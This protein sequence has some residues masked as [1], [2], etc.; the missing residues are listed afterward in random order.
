LQL[1]FTTFHPFEI[2]KIILG[3]LQA[4]HIYVVS[5]SASTVSRY[6]AG[7]PLL[8]GPFQWDMNCIA[9]L[10]MVLKEATQVPVPTLIG[11]TQA[12]V[13]L[14]GR[15]DARVIVNVDVGIMIDKRSVDGSHASRLRGVQLQITFQRKVAML[16][17]SFRGCPGFPHGHVQRLIRGF[18][19]QSLKMFTGEVANRQKFLEALSAL[20]EYLEWSQ[21]MHDL[22]NVEQA[23]AAVRERIEDWLLEEFEGRAVRAMKAKPQRQMTVSAS[24]EPIARGPRERDVP[25]IEFGTP[26]AKA[27]QVDLFDLLAVRG[28]A[29]AP[30][31]SEADLLDLFA[32]APR[33][34]TKSPSQ[35]SL[36]SLIDFGQINTRLQSLRYFSSHHKMG[37]SKNDRREMANGSEWIGVKVW[38]P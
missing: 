7:L 32:A 3:M 1:L 21:V 20:P 13:V 26:G 38:D 23:P 36:E 29:A 37:I 10:P 5:S 12:E 27:Q 14:E 8:I 2:A 35:P 19:F 25:L 4:R 33:R 22:L 18:I 31:R 30:G 34:P 28:P 15:I 6:V 11:L 17:E 24:L 16:L 9:I